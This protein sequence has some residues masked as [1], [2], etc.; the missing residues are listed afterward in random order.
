MNEALEIFRTLN[1]IFHLGDFIYTIRENEG[2]GWS[3][4]KVVAWATACSRLEKLLKE[5]EKCEE[6]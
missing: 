3:G 1:T 6:V 2:L 5:N 4:P